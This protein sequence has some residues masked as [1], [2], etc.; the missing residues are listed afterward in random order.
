MPF[1]EKNMLTLFAIAEIAEVALCLPLLYLFFHI[2][3][4]EK[5]YFCTMQTEMS[6]GSAFSFMANFIF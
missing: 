6:T 5:H 2:L 4:P 1:N 3:V